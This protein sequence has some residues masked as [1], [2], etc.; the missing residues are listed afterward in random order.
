MT[1]WLWRIE[2]GQHLG[3]EVRVLA[4]DRHDLGDQAMPSWPLSVDAADEGRDEARIALAGEQR[5]AGRE[6]RASRSP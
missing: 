5:L 2:A 6:A 4:V 3:L 1:C